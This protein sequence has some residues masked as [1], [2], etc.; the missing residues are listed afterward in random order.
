MPLFR[1]PII[2]LIK[3]L[4]PQQMKK[5]SALALLIVFATAFLT[6]CKAPH[7][8]EAYSKIETKST[9]ANS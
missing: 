3:A 6:S 1:D 9:R 7:K 8:C 5:F 4:K 2:T